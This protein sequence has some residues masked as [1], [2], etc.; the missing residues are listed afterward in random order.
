MKTSK[1][2]V[3]MVSCL[4]VLLTLVYYDTFK[5]LCE[6]FTATDSYYSHGFLIPLVTIFLIW[7]KRTKLKLLPVNVSVLGLLLLVLGLSFH[8]LSILMEVYFTSGFSILMVLFGLSLFLFGKE[9]TRELSFPLCFLI[10]MLPLPLVAVNAISFPMRLFATKAAVK[11][12]GVFNLP[13]IQKGFE[14]Y[15]PQGVLVVGNPCSGL[16]SLIAFMALGTIFAYYLKANY[17]RKLSLVALAIPI[18]ILS[19]IGRIILLSLISYI[20]GT[21]VAMGFFHEFS[22]I[23]VFVIGFICLVAVKGGLECRDYGRDV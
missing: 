2:V 16:R 6:R 5:W 3:I 14:I 1:S 11:F 4:A 12:L 15:F 22:G 19:N 7:Q 10:F 8:L 21:E 18:A 9:I 23:L 20:Y 13:I 17:K